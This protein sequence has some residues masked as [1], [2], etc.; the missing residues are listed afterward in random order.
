VIHDLHYNAKGYRVH[1]QRELEPI[2]AGGMEGSAQVIRVCVKWAV[3]H[4]SVFADAQGPHRHFA[5][6]VPRW[7]PSNANHRGFE[8][9]GSRSF[10]SLS[11]GRCAHDAV[12]GPPAD[13]LS[14]PR[15]GRDVLSS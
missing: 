4:A 5:S 12:F 7:S 6:L 2:T 11:L 10:L 1:G 14:P 9:F 8:I 15:T 3:G 13:S